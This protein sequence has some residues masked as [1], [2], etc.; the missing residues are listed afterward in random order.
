MNANEKFASTSKR[1]ESK[2]RLCTTLGKLAVVL[3][4]SGCVVSAQAFESPGDGVYEDRIDW[5]ISI[6]MTGTASGQQVPWVRG[7]ESYMNTVNEAGGVNGRKIN[8]MVEDTRYDPSLDR[9]VFEKLVNQTPVLGISGL[10]SSSAQAA[11]M[12]ELRSGKVPVIGVY[13]VTRA[14]L[15]PPTPMYYAGYCGPKEMAQVGTNFFSDHLDLKNPKVAIFHMDVAGGKEFADFVAAETTKRGGTAKA[16]PVKVGAADVTSHV[17]EVNDMKPDF[18]ALYGVPNPTILF[19]R[20]MAQYGLDIP[21]F[22]I[23]HLGTPQVYAA[24]GAEVGK[25]YHFVSCFTPAS[26]TD[27]NG[28]IK[29]LIA[30][31]DKYGYSEFTDNINFVG[32]WVAGQVVAG[33]VAKAGPEPTREKLVASMDEGFQL[34]TKGLS[35]PVKYTKNDKR[36]LIGLR[37]YVYDY[38]AKQFKAFGEYS[39]YVKFVDPPK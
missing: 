20:T 24:L 3:A 9:V 34:D 2:H 36:G 17:L 37:P 39:D 14:G 6:D 10:G 35:S 4:F 30:A 5:G 27:P 28:G 8:V 29:E 23:M 16:L 18:V 33:A 32:G 1:G 19:M 13:A 12:P 15:E 25:N 7:F 38:A 31:A 26:A 11:Y 21:A 22:A